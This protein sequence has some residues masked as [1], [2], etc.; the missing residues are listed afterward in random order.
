M[1]SVGKT[2]R[3][4][5]CASIGVAAIIKGMAVVMQSECKRREMM[6]YASIGVA[7]IIKGMAVVT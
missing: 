4:M 5:E 3:R 6:E 1:R 7:A 2:R